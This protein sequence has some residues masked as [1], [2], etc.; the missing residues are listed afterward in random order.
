MR[1]QIL[2][3]TERSDQENCEKS[4]VAKNLLA[5][6]LQNPSKTAD[7][8]HIS[9]PGRNPEFSATPV[10]PIFTLISAEGE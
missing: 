1:K 9:Q 3:D 8:L 2:S 10:C 5:K 7:S 6:D 4:M